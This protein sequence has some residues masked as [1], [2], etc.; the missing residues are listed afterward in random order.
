MAWCVSLLPQ[1]ILFTDCAL[2]LSIKGF[3][4]IVKGYISGAND[5]S[6]EFI[7]AVLAK[8]EER[9]RSHAE[10]AASLFAEI[11]ATAAPYS[12]ML[13]SAVDSALGGG[14]GSQKVRVC[15]SAV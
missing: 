6:A 2:Q 7:T 5:N 12:S 11:A 8:G 4:D 14:E 10:I 15:L 3:I 13:A 1:S 9:G